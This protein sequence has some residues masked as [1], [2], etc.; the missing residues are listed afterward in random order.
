M[1][2]SENKC[3][4]PYRIR[5]VVTRQQRETQGDL[6]ACVFVFIS[7][8]FLSLPLPASLLLSGYQP[9]EQPSGSFFLPDSTSATHPVFCQ[10]P[11]QVHDDSSST[12]VYNIA[13]PLMTRAARR[14]LFLS[15]HSP[16]HNLTTLPP[17]A[18][19]LTTRAAFG[20]LFLPS[21]VHKDTLE[22]TLL[23]PPK[24]CS[25]MMVSGHHHI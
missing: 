1:C 18:N 9:Q 8:I 13:P 16:M 22:Y 21:F 5:L 2:G 15:T 23:P 3:I 6:H 24:C 25:L 4:D 14:L 12:V 19:L 10:S 20:L 17:I 7:L 11:I